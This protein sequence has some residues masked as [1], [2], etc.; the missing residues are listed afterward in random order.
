MRKKHMLLLLE[1][2][3][4]AAQGEIASNA[5]HGGIY[6][7]GLSGEGYAGGYAQ[8]INDVIAALHDAPPSSSRYW[9]SWTRQ[10]EICEL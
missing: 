2:A 10:R 5:S 9:P 1:E 8:A 6:A 4:K 7:S 3:L